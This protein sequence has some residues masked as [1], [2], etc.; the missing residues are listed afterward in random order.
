LCGAAYGRE[1]GGFEQRELGRLYLENWAEGYAM[2]KL[3]PVAR[4][5]VRLGYLVRAQ[6]FFRIFP[7]VSPEVMDGQRQMAA[8]PLRKLLWPQQL[9]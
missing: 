9:I 5:A 7:E 8:R 6:A 1:P 2:D 3:I 4:A